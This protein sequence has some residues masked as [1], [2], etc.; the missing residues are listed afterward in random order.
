MKKE[1]EFRAVLVQQCKEA[2]AFSAEEYVAGK[3]QN[4]NEIVIPRC[5]KGKKMPQWW[6]REQM[7][8][9]PN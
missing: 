9:P 4:L 7:G 6:I 3:L 5:W 1:K 2:D 8:L